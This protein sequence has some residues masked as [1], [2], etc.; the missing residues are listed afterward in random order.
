MSYD[1]GKDDTNNKTVNSSSI[2]GS[3]AN[4]KQTAKT[5]NLKV[6]EVA[7]QRDVGRKIARIDPDIAERLNISAGD[8]LE[9]SSGRKKTT[10]LSWPARETD[11]GKRL[12]RIDG[13]TRNKL[14]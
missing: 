13:Y 2:G 3:D 10:V 1:I 11:R 9:L 8:V 7:E 5:T 6:A 12:I 4:T 14:D